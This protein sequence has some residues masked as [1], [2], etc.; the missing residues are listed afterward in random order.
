[1]E[2]LR[3][4]AVAGE[5]KAVPKNRALNWTK[6]AACPQAL[7]RA[8][9]KTAF[10]EQA[11]EALRGPVYDC[12]R[13]CMPAVNEAVAWVTWNHPEGKWRRRKRPILIGRDPE[14]GSRR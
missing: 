11:G 12:S 1:M 7:I 8:L 6:L 3:G 14:T 4:A 2:A 13:R 9:E 5:R 10:G